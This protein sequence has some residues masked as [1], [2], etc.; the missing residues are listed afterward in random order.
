[1]NANET[2]SKRDKVKFVRQA[3]D[4]IFS[5]TFNVRRGEEKEYLSF[6]R[7]INLTISSRE[8][9]EEFS[10]VCR[11]IDE[12]R[13]DSLPRWCHCSR[14]CSPIFSVLV[15]VFRRSSINHIKGERT[16]LCR[17]YFHRISSKSGNQNFLHIGISLVVVDNRAWT[18]NAD[19]R[20]EL[21]SRRR[22][23]SLSSSRNSSPGCDAND[24][25]LSEF[26]TREL[27][28]T[29]RSMCHDYWFEEPW[30]ELDEEPW[31]T[32]KY[33]SNV[34]DLFEMRI[35]ALMEEIPMQSRRERGLESKRRRRRR[36]SI[37]VRSL[38]VQ[39]TRCKLIVNVVSA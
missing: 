22:L 1:M 32:I 3:S 25:F 13:S 17:R 21:A 31:T 15:R 37:F 16:E 38:M 30:N 6:P 20:S 29:C 14:H 11:S 18:R 27:A 9:K 23:D 5:D 19:S 26:L 12:N 28:S 4:E 24:L 35:T 2:L 10:F 33:S 34:L 8:T 7:K 36:Y 39:S